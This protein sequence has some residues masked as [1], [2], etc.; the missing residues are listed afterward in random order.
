MASDRTFN[1]FINTGAFSTVPV[2]LDE[3]DLA[4]V[5]EN[6]GCAVEEL[7]LAD[8]AETLA[9]RALQNTPTLGWCC[10]GGS[11]RGQPTLSLGDE[12]EVD[13]VPNDP[14]ASYVETTR[15]TEDPEKE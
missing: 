10:Q 15:K 7:T 14:L 11:H 2:T 1:V 6:L 13:E 5:A 3:D 8:L 4:R 9:D 12:W